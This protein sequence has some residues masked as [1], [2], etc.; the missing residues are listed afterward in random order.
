MIE[1]YKQL[2]FT[3]KFFSFLIITIPISL[4]SG[5]F[6]PDLCVSLCAIFLLFK[7]KN[8]KLFKNYFVFLFFFFYLIIIISSVINFDL[9]SLKSSLF[10]F[11]FGLFSLLFWNLIEKDDR[12]LDKLFLVLLFSFSILI[13]DSLFQY[14]NGFNIL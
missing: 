11:R 3:D 4:I 6:I 7:N 8:K 2:S 5:P 9:S 1:N 13:F 12:I 14:F 10:Y